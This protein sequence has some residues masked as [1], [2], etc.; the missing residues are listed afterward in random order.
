MKLSLVSIDKDGLIR[1]AADGNIT[2][3]DFS[4]DG[5]NPLRQLLGE[6]WSSNRVVLNLA[7]TNY[8]DSSAIGW[9]I[10]TSRAF[11]TGGGAFAIHSVQPA[12][13]QIMDVLRVQKVVPTADDENAARQIALGQASP[14]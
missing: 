2:S 11:R 1:V 10:G 12:V 8:V 14:Q 6:T 3:G 5:D 4:A 9:L 7:R 13:R